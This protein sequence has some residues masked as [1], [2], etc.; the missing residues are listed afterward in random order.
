VAKKQKKRRRKGL[1]FQ[2]PLQERAP[3]YQTSFQCA[4]LT[5]APQADTKSLPLPF[6]GHLIYKS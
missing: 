5:I 2:Y 3:N 4:P 1:G 6:G